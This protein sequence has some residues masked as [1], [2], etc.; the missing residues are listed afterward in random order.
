MI[1]DFE[2]ENYKN[3][4]SSEQPQNENQDEEVLCCEL[5]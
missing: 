2:N 3:N 1:E 5:S 4:E